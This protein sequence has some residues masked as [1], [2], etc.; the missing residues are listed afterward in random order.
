VHSKPA[1]AH[2]TEPPQE[3]DAKPK[4]KPQPVQQANASASPPGNGGLIS[5]AQPVVPAGNFDSRWTGV[6]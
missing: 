5:G 2:N 4:A 6:Q 1:A 3:A